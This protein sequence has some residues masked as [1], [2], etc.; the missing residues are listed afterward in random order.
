[1]VCNG[2]LWGSVY[3]LGAMG[4]IVRCVGLCWWLWGS[5]CE[6]VSVVGGSVYGLGWVDTLTGDWR[7][8]RMRPL[9]LCM[10]VEK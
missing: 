3:G 1:M 2:W 4:G 7:W 5:V 9:F 8:T 10:D 6:F